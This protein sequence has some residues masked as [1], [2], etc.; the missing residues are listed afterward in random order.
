[1]NLC[2]KWIRPTGCPWHFSDI[3]CYVP[4]VCK[5]PHPAIVLAFWPRCNSEAM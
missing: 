5:N 4:P 1:M 2:M 3:Y